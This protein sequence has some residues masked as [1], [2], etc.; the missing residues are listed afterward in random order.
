VV[1][2]F[3]L[4]V[5]YD[6]YFSFAPKRLILEKIIENLDRK[7]LQDLNRANT[8][9]NYFAHCDQRVLDAVDFPKR[10]LKEN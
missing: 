10:K 1:L 7:M 5:L 6:E 2:P 3:L 8:I 4:E 9:R